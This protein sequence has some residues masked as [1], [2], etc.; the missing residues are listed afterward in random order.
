VKAK[1]ILSLCGASAHRQS[2]LILAAALVAFF[3]SQSAHATNAAWGGTQAVPVAVV[4][5]DWENINNWTAAIASVPGTAPGETATFNANNGATIRV[6][7]LDGSVPGVTIK[8]IT[9]GANGNPYTLGTGAA[10]SQTL[11][12]EGTSVINVTA[13]N[14]NSPVINAKVN[15]GNAGGDEGFSITQNSETNGAT[16]AGGISTAQLGIK[17]FTVAGA[18]STLISGNITDGP[19]SDVANK[20]VLTKNGGSTLSLSGTNSYSGATSANAG[21]LSFRNKA[22][23]S[24]NTTVTAAA[25]GSIT[26]GVKDADSNFYSAADVDTLFNGAALD[27]FTLDAAS[28]V[29]IDTSAGDFTY[30]SNLPAVAR[31]L[32]KVGANTLTLSGTNAYTGQT[33]IREGAISVSSIATNLSTTQINLG[34]GNT[35]GTLIYTGG[36]FEEITRIVRLNGAGGSGT[37][38]QSGTDLLKLSGNVTAN[39]TTNKALTLSGSSTGTGEIAGV[40]SN[41]PVGPGPAFAQFYIALTKNGTG[42]WTLSG[43]NTYGKT[44]S[45]NNVGRTT[46]TDGTLALGAIGTVGG[47]LTASPVQV[48]NGG[49]FAV[50]PGI[51]TTTNNS[52]T[53]TGASITLAM[54]NNS[55][56]TMADGFINTFNVNGTANLFA[57][58]GIAPKFTFD[59]DGAANT[60]DKMAISGAVTNTNAGGLVALTPVTALDVGDSFTIATALSG[61]DVNG[62]SLANGGVTSFGS[63]AY[64]LSLVNSSSTSTITVTGMG[65]LNAYYTGDQ[66]STLNASSGANINWATDIT[67][68][69]D[70]PAQPTNLTNV[71]FSATGATNLTVA[72]LGQDYT[73]NTLNFN[74]AA[75]AVTLNNGGSNT[76]TLNGGLNTD[77]GAPLATVNVPVILGLGQTWT[78]NGQLVLGAPLTTGGNSLTLAGTG[79]TAISGAISGASAL[80]VNPSA[81]DTGTVT[82][83]GANNYTGGITLLAGALTLQNNQSAA[84]GSISVGSSLVANSILTIDT[85]ATVALASGSTFQVGSIGTAGATGIT[86]TAN[87]AGAVTNAGPLRVGRIG[88]LNLTSGATWAQSGD[89]TIQGAGNITAQMTIGTGASLT[90]T[91]ANTIK[92]QPPAGPANYLGVSRLTVSG[93]L[94]TG[95]GFEA[96]TDNPNTA[97][98]QVELLNGTIRLSA[99]IPNLFLADGVGVD[100]TKLLVTSA[101]TIDTNGFNTTIAQVITGAGGSLI[102]DSAGTLTLTAANTYTGNTTVN[103]GTLDIVDNAQLRF[104]TGATSGTGQNVLSGAGT[105]TLNGDFFIDT[106]ATDASAIT[107]GSWQIENAASLPGAYGIDFTVVGWTNAG[108]DTWIKSVGT[109]NYTFNELDG[110]VSMIDT[111]PP[112]D[113]YTAWI[114][115]YTPNALLPDAAS[116]L[117]G[118]DPDGDDYSNLM[119]FVLDGSPVVSSQSIRPNQT[120]NATDIILTFKRS[121]ASESPVTTQMVQIST[122][123]VDWTTIPAITIGAGDNLPSVGVVE[124]GAAADD[125]TVTIPRSGSLKKFVRLHVVK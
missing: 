37:I 8:N 2:N 34:N 28:G 4:D 117:P 59:A 18:G 76:L 6:I 48:S 116:K 22:A 32:Y 50:T 72:S 23:R 111:A 100:A 97:T 80:S 35:S 124:N 83:S 66:G 36:V 118:A 13:T 69:T 67:G 42:K 121:D 91:G 49:T 57:A 19:T 114:E 101:G 77:A 73:F 106:A 62:F 12:L 25:A 85:G 47:S 63:T 39:G 3:S 79:T 21:V 82:L 44:D 54:N 70:A 119:E 88:I 84:T 103:A 7:D 51:V 89:M 78:N 68:A 5:D 105:V 110:T 55:A 92:V 65:A 10:G 90:Y 102:K 11:T 17:T 14:G 123:L 87:V 98:G 1:S 99:S 27:G 122:D 93:T 20:L 45:T 9:F 26:L 115:G 46:I 61:L 104:I 31:A 15:L 112:A 33:H 96:V 24:P 41:P 108:S 107:S 53:S 81:T 60:S 38:T 113:P 40:I 94:T 125:I 109:K 52:I 56:F 58:A 95:Q 120:V 16:F 71:Y 86:A 43:V 74:N 30:T 75:G 64:T 29:G